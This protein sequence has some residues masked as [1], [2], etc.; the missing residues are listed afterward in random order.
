MAVLQS[1][2]EIMQ[3]LVDDGAALDVQ[4][5]DGYTPLYLASWNPYKC[6]SEN[7][8]GFTDRPTDRRPG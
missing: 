6:R 8:A 1:N 2:A 3:L 7:K 5:D 4:D